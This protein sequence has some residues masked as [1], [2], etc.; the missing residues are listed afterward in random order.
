MK[1][2]H[3]G[4][5]FCGVGAVAGPLL[6]WHFANS[7]PDAVYWSMPIAARISCGLVATGI[8]VGTGFC[9]VV[10]LCN[11]DWPNEN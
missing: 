7:L 3:R 5:F 10:G 1:K 6:V 8:W 9:V 2:Q 11:W 4:R